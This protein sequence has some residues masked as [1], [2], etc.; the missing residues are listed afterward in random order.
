M[1]VTVYPYRP[2]G[3]EQQ[4]RKGGGSRRNLGA[5]RSAVEATHRDATTSSA[6]LTA[7]HCASLQ[8]AFQR[9]APQ[10]GTEEQDARE[11]E[12]CDVTLSSS[13]ACLID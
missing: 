10:R 1:K 2:V 3:G 12:P 7:I 9:Q 6:E 13:N 11:D 4:F 5:S 8:A